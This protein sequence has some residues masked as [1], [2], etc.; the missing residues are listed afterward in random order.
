MAS[1]TKGPNYRTP[2]GKSEF[3]RSTQD[4]KTV[5]FTVDA[6]TVVT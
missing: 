4:I 3:L 5:S 1:F 2:F 6:A